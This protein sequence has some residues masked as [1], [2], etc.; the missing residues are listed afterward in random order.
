MVRCREED[1]QKKKKHKNPSQKG[2][3]G[4]LLLLLI[5]V[6]SKKGGLQNV[7]QSRELLFFS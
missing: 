1:S 7:P 4:H 6:P 2:K 5:K 3:K